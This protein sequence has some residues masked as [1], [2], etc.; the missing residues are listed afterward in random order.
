MLQDGTWRVGDLPVVHQPTLSF[1]KR[2]LVF[3]DSGAFVVDGPQRMPVA[4][5]GPAFQVVALRLAPA[6]GSALAPVD[7]DS[8]EPIA[9]LRADQTSGRIDC[10]VRRG[11][12]RAL[13]SRAAHQALLQDVEA[14]EGGFMLCIGSAD[15]DPVRLA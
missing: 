15:P 10:R 14:R 6:T 11:Q 3:E 4:V 9:D 5:E 1:L 13:L 7:D 8:E 12:A 2:R